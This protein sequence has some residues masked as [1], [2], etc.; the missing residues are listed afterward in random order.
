M[1]NQKKTNQLIG[2]QPY[3]FQEMVNGKDLYNHDKKPMISS[4]YVEFFDMTTGNCFRITYD[5]PF[6]NDF[7]LSVAAESASRD[8]YMRSG[9]DWG[10]P[11]VVDP[12]NWKLSVECNSESL[13]ICQCENG[14]FTWPV[15][16][17]KTL[18]TKDEDSPYFLGGYDYTQ[19]EFTWYSYLYPSQ[20]IEGYT[21]YELNSVSFQSITLVDR[22]FGYDDPISVMRFN[23]E[24]TQQL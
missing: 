16:Y 10:K 15:N 11:L 6:L 7:Q 4:P 2:Q 13:V 17:H 18:F 14:I 9:D 23:F 24:L 22:D 8:P 3:P 12:Q 20:H 1:R 21:N 19:S 5:N